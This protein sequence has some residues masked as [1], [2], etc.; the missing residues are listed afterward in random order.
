MKPTELPVV[1]YSPVFSLCFLQENYFFQFL[2]CMDGLF[3]W[4]LLA[5]CYRQAQVSWQDAGQ[6]WRKG[7]KA[8]I[9][10][11]LKPIIPLRWDFLSWAHPLVSRVIQLL[12]LE[13]VLLTQSLTQLVPLQ[14]ALQDLWAHQTLISAALIILISV[15]AVMISLMPLDVPFSQICRDFTPRH[16]TSL[17]CLGT[18]EGGSC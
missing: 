1:L 17:S 12:E 18:R 15:G 4:G 13:K 5:Q 8:G 7:C 9:S 6:F 10:I 2:Q 11:A 14:E 16:H 3:C